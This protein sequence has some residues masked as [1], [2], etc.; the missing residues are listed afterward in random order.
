MSANDTSASD[1][2]SLAKGDIRFY[3][4]VVPA[5]PVGDYLIN[6]KQ[7]IDPKDT[8]I[9]ETHV[10]S[11]VFAV[12]GPRYALPTEDLSSIFPPNNASGIFNQFLP[13]VVLGKRELPWE[14]NV[15]DEDDAATR[16]PWL[17][18]LLFVEGEKIDGVDALLEPKLDGWKANRTM[19]GIIPARAFH[20]HAPDRDTLWPALEREWYE[21]EE[22]LA[23]TSTTFIDISPQAF[24]TLLPGKEDLRYM[25]HARRV[26]PTAKESGILKINGEGWYSV[27]TGNR[28]PDAPPAGSGA[29]G[30]RNIVHL[31]SLEGFENYVGGASPLPAGTTRVRMISFK[32]WSFTCLPQMGESFTQMM[33][34][35]LRDAHGAQ[36]PTELTLQ[37]PPPRDPTP[38]ETFAYNA[39]RNGYVPLRYQTRL[40]ERTFGWYRGPFSPIPVKNFVATGP[41]TPETPSGWKRFGTASAAMI[42]DKEHGIFDASYG[43]AW[44]TG[45]MMA[46]SDPLFGPKL[47][48]WQQKGHYMVDMILERR[49]QM[50][51]M[52]TPGLL[53]GAADTPEE[54]IDML[55]PYA[56]TDN[57]M[58]EIITG[59]PDRLAPK[60]RASQGLRSDGPSPLHDATPDNDATLLEAAPHRIPYADRHSPVPDPDLL[61]SLLGG[62]PA[63][64]LG[65][66]ADE[67]P[68]SGAPASGATANVAGN[69]AARADMALRQA[70]RSKGTKEL[71]DLVAWLS[72]LYLLNGVPF[73][74][75]IAHAGLLTPESVRFFYV[76]SNWLDIMI[77]G[78]LSIGIESSRDT[79]YQKLM[80][81]LVQKGTVSEARKERRMLL[82]ASARPEAV[83][84]PPFDQ[85]KLTGLLLRSAVVSGWPGMEI[86]AYART[87]P[88]S[89]EPDP[90][91]HIDLLRMERLSGEVMLCLWPAVPAV[92]TINEPH[93]GIA[94][95]FQDAPNTR[96]RDGATEE[97]GYWLYLR[98]LDAKSYGMPLPE[99]TH[100]I[101]AAAAGLI[102]PDRRV[103]I[104]GADGLVAAIRGKLDGSPTINVRDFAV[105]MVKVPETALFAAPSTPKETP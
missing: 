7:R 17:A 12:Q 28:L 51:A 89:P 78:A 35:L 91:T 98:S 49:H 36:K 105:Q 44:E 30:K 47:R 75:L 3:D 53:K 61:E 48:D 99:A 87:R 103:R 58:V 46:L 29:P 1:C 23:D 52:K 62:R 60:P 74:N 82:G 16:T 39:I 41:I 63:P 27:I 85:E 9:D 68:A 101:D 26:D 96:P 77:E 2:E 56:L 72:K 88:D 65:A 24:A 93:E 69:V 5:L 86:H 37:V 59:L 18:L 67:A 84:A 22:F 81:D 25:A 94:F 95:G 64:M 38:E 6:V 32:S 76:D 19:T 13:H 79:L 8:E 50:A 33:N 90:S 40:G 21:S 97:T 100:H 71:E 57:L 15:F 83:N 43:V 73:E 31:I 80:W 34:G 102:G 10:A 54:V 92:V 20:D 4:N 55:A 14:R 70:V 104:S 45:R 42:Y 66:M 11:Q